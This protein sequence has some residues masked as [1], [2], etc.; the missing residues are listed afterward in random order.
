MATLIGVVSQVVG[1]VFAV[2]SDGSRRPISE[3]DR[4]YAGEQL[5]TGA[6][7][8]VAIAMTNGQQLTLGRDSSMTLDAQML[9]YRGES[10]PPVAE[11]PPATPSD[12]DLTDVERLQAAIEAGVDPTLEGEATA[13]GP[14]AGAGGAGGVG[15]GHSFVLLDE[16]G[17][18]LDPVIGFPTEG[19]PG[20]PEFPDPD[21]V[22]GLDDPAVPNGFPE[23][24]DDSNS[25]FEDAEGPITGNVL[26]NDD[27]GPDLPLSFVSWGSTDATYGVFTDTGG[28]TYTYAL[29]SDDPRVQGLDDGESLTET[30]TYIIVDGNGDQDT[31]T[32]TITIQG[33]ND[34]PVITVSGDPQVEGSDG[35]VYESGLQPNGS[36][37][38][39]NSIVSVGSFSLSDA[40]G[41]DDL[42]SVTING[43][44]V[45]IADLVGHSSTGAHGTLE[46]TGYDAATG[47]GT[48]S[49][50]LTSPTVDVEGELETDVFTLTVFDGTVSSAP[51]TI[52]IEIVDDEPVANSDTGNLGLN[53]TLTVNA[54]NGVLANDVEGAD[55]AVVVG[56]AKGST[57]VALDNTG[58]L[59]VSLAG[60]YGTL[61]L[62]ADGSY[63]Y[64]RKA[65]AKG[66]VSDVFT[67]TIKDG[68]GDLSH[69][70]LTINL[71]DST[72]TV[73]IPDP[74]G[75]TTKVYE[76]GLPAR[77]GEPAGS[78]EADDSETTSG[79]IGFTS[80]DG[81]Q[82]V[83]LNGVALS[84]SDQTVADDATGTL[85]ARYD[86]D[87]VTG[88]GTI[89]YS[90]TLKDN[91][92]GDGTSVG[93]A[94]VVT[95]SDGDT[96]PAGSLV[97]NIVDDEPVAVN[98]ANSSEA[99][100]Q[101]NTN[102]MI[103]LDVSGSMT[104]SADF[105]GYNRI[106]AAKLAILELLEQ[107][108][109]MGE[110]K[111]RLV[112]FA[113]GATASS[114]GWMTVEAA[115]AAVLAIG[116]PSG[117]TN[118]D[119][120]LTTAM[121]AWDTAGK[122]TTDV[123][124][125]SYFLSDGEPN[126][127]TNSVGIDAAE[128]AA[129]VD[130]LNANKIESFALGMGPAAQVTSGG[131]PGANNDYLD[132][133]AYDGSSGTNTNAIAV[134][135]FADLAAV[136]ADT[137]QTAALTGSLAGGAGAGF[138]ADGGYVQSLVVEGET[139]TYDKASNSVNGGS[140]LLGNILIIN[141]SNGSRL[142]VNMLSGSY[143]YIPP[144]VVAVAIYLSVQFTLADNDGDISGAT[145]E[146]SVDP[147]GIPLIVRDDFIVTNQ[148]AFSVPDWALLANDS[149]SAI[150]Q[151]ITAVNGAG[152][153]SNGS[154]L[155]P[156]GAV[157]TAITGANNNEFFI[158]TNT[159][160]G[161]S[162]TGKVSVTV[163]SGSTINGTFR[164]E[165][166]I[167]GNSG[168]TLDGRAGNDILMGGAG[169]DT[170]IYRLGEGNDTIVEGS[171]QG[172][173]DSLSIQAG[174]AAL[175]AL[176][177]YDSDAGTDTGHL[178]IELNG[179][180]IT[181]N[182]HYTAGTSG[183][184]AQIGVELINFNGLSFAGY[185]FGSGD[186]T[187]SKLDPA[188][189]GSGASATR[190]V[191]GTSGNDFIA[192]ESGIN[193]VISGGNGN[194]LIFGNNG[195]DTLNGGAGNDL[196][197]GGAGND[198]LNGGDGDDVLIGGIGDDLMS[199]GAGSDTFVWLAG[200]GG[201]DVI[202]DFVAGTDSLNLSDLLVGVT[203][204]SNLESY[205]NFS[206]GLNTVITVDADGNAGNGVSGPVIT[207]QGVN[208]E[209]AYG[210]SGTAAVIDKML[211]DDS[212]HVA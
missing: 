175:T 49:Y 69:T 101:I 159:A 174:G 138:G 203:G 98:I 7:G 108:E 178:V 196:L 110:V 54:A 197:V 168:D 92:S 71:G 90:Y 182:N 145:L 81:L 166:L 75:D 140:P 79:S 55:G 61:T 4:V 139:Y 73:S 32:L 38:S 3:G 161:Q 133:I 181:I 42:V 134:D 68:D 28:G 86:Y 179:Q 210:V 94:V 97:I 37:V 144:S 77:P 106:E 19:L 24:I 10:Q 112:T 35:I 107:Y 91:T 147:A 105:G 157:S 173:S 142:E 154:V 185:S 63:E 83:S 195:N 170:Y 146:L 206:F 47:Q 65:G 163:Q 34:V 201:N 186:Y 43:T 156:N 102:L 111:V 78:S 85:T 198:T 84:G 29:N 169:N 143:T 121:D 150:G 48:Y 70:T 192:G 39:P 123:Q 153:G 25:I 199:G 209:T 14:G 162:D 122:L 124:N 80:R 2:A 23:A 136:L 126:R 88:V 103:V 129:W 5:V 44:M 66:G 191:S 41:L 132:A 27:P 22:L 16:V 202:T 33:A 72:P 12:A 21:P 177:A 26:A 18:A 184:S 64:A 89:H 130:F 164:D 127:P 46:I 152:L 115:K 137:A 211:G 99:T 100:S 131:A 194:D 13:A 180:T 167:G 148:S 40:D 187:L 151:A 45:L 93:F 82:S 208:L 87:V 15:G 165:I 36:Q 20:G 176:Y 183:S 119:A 58:T 96:S 95:D 160:G 135:N 116:T 59:N 188:N 104:S 53:T 117:N 149:G 1:E 62:Q 205:L 31:A 118:Y 158:Y 172:S 6:S 212:L 125:V 114:G 109:S 60:E 67:Y 11:T 193:N 76:E 9:A 190:T 155:H 30:F 50:T 8:A 207:L 120:A 200:D 74:G 17:G 141:L 52:T 128:E 51:A 113:A 57:G 56:V 171:G 204:A 189:T